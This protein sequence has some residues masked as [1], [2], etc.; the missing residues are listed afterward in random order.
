VAVAVRLVRTRHGRSPDQHPLAWAALR[1]ADDL[2]Y[3]TG[4][5]AGALR[6]REPGPI[7]PRIT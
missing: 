5:W 3:G 6:E 1:V 2:A 7:L 4:V